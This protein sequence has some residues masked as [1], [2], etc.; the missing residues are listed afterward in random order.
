MLGN[1][2][3]STR[4]QIPRRNQP[5]NDA[6]RRRRPFDRAFVHMA[7]PWRRVIAPGEET[8]FKDGHGYS[9]KV[10]SVA[11]GVAKLPDF[12]DTFLISAGKPPFSSSSSL[13]E[14]MANPSGR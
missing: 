3:V 12:S 6:P 5:T 1:L 10:R 7:T 8:Q 13:S 2:F 9:S 4:F 14:G 11:D